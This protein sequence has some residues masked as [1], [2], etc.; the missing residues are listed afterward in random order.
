MTGWDLIERIQN[1]ADSLSRGE[2]V[3]PAPPLL[4]IVETETD[5]DELQLC[6]AVPWA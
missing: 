2:K 5:L 4:L 6:L 3:I 1:R